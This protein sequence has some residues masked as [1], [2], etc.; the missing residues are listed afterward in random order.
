M[1]IALY[2]PR[3]YYSHVIKIRRIQGS[4][5][6]IELLKAITTSNTTAENCCCEK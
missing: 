2:I 3:H 5:K 6:A 4:A 1:N